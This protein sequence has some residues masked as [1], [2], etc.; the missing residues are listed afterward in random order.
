MSKVDISIVILTKNGT[1]YIKEVLE[2]IYQQKTSLRFEI[3]AVDSGSTDGTLNILKKF[4][5]ILHQISP[6]K[7]NHGGTRNLGISLS[8]GKLIILLTQDATPADENWMEN[9]TKDLW[10]DPMVAGVYA[11]KI[12]RIESNPIERREVIQFP[13]EGGTQKLIFRI[14]DHGWEHYRKYAHIYRYFSNTC[15]AI[16]RSVWEK[17][18]FREV[19]FAE[20]N[21]WAQE[22]L[23]AG[24]TKIYEPAAAVYHS[25]D[26]SPIVYMRR[27][28]D[29]ACGMKQLF[30]YQD[31][32]YF[33]QII[34]RAGRSFLEDT[35]FIKKDNNLPLKEKIG[36]IC[37]SPIYHILK[38]TGTYLGA[39]YEKIPK[40][41]IK[42]LSLQYRLIRSS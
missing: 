18:P 22:V 41:W 27:C 8:K 42:K 5:V 13:F 20:D 24:Y 30:G 21:L 39:H 3:I 9:L 16:R 17:I 4:S 25:H 6:E 10:N 12:P 33:W 14:S 36:W 32:F 28:F 37:F 19:N 38:N 1:P 31:T 23:E 29:H 26:Y 34:L 7:F 40:R 15:S 2:A 35:K 11:R